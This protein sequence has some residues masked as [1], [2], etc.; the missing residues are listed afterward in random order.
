MNRRNFLK[1]LGGMSAG[2]VG[3]LALPRLGGEQAAA[4]PPALAIKGHEYPEPY[5]VYRVKRTIPVR[6][7]EILVEGMLN[8]Y[9]V[10]IERIA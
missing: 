10:G 7:G 6:D 1:R 4:R 5:A 2:A 8:D 3:L 9:E